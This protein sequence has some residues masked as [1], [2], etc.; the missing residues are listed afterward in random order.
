M[1]RTLVFHDPAYPRGGQPSEHA[2]STLPAFLGAARS[3]NLVDPERNTVR[4][5]KRLE[6]AG[7]DVTLRLYGRVNHMT[8]AGAFAAPLRF[9][10]PVLDDVAGFVTGTSGRTA[11]AA[12]AAR[13][14]A[15]AG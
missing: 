2:A 9:L 7:A 11:K 14:S 12:P 6:A 10:A 13:K 4:L 5:A 1:R 15:R 8:L 3:D